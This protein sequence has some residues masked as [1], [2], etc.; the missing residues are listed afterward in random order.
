MREGV[1]EGGR[2]WRKSEPQ[3]RTL[4]FL[5]LSRLESAIDSESL[6]WWCCHL[7]SF[8]VP[9]T[10]LVVVVVHCAVGVIQAVDHSLREFIS[11]LLVRLTERERERES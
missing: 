10:S 6:L 5:L 4:L 7:L 11:E 1:A 9:F 8:L 2:E 3:A